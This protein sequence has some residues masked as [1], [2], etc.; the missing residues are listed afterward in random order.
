MLILSELLYIVHVYQGS[1]AGNT[2]A[3]LNMATTTP[4]RRSDLVRPFATG[5][6]YYFK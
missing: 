2:H 6:P 3:Y 5:K 1:N 4:F